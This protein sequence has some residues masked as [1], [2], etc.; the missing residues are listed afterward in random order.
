M[1]QSDITAHTY[2][3]VPGQLNPVRK[4]G[5]LHE[6]RKW[7]P[8]AEY[9]QQ[10]APSKKNGAILEHP[11]L[12]PYFRCHVRRPSGQLMRCT[13]IIDSVPVNETQA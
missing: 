5:A 10:H 4:S 6:C 1:C 8:I 12:G 3:W 11:D 13:G 2:D 7:E 9:A